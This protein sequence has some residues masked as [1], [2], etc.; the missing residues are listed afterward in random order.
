MFWLAF[1]P[2]LVK[3]GLK[4]DWLDQILIENPRRFLAFVPRTDAS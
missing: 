4:A 1:A 2:M 3:A